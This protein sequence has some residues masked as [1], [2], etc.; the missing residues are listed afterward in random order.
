MILDPQLYVLCGVTITAVCGAVASYYGYKNH[1]L[2]TQI[3]VMTNNN[4]SALQA[5]LKEVREQSA[6]LAEK[7][8]AAAVA[9]KGPA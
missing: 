6:V 8:I 7:A 1:T 5:E 4:Y 9:A 3:H 2:G